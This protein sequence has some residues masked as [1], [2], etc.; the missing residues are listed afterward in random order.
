[1]QLIL[2]RMKQFEHR[3]WRLPIASTSTPQARVVSFATAMMLFTWSAAHRSTRPLPA[4]AVTARVAATH[5][6]GPTHRGRASHA[7]AWG[8]T[9][10]MEHQAIHELLG[11]VT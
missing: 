7:A 10:T 3:G 5:G 4:A 6:R 1:M 11:D 8:H 9:C 2:K